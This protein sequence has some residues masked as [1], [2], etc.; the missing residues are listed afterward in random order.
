Y[1]LLSDDNFIEYSN[2]TSKGAKMPRGDKSAMMLFEVNLPNLDKQQEISAYLKSVDNKIQLNTQTNQTLEQIAQAIFKSWFVDFDP[3]KA[4]VD[5]LA[6]GGSQADAERTAMQ[7]IS[8]KTDAELTQM[9]Q[10]Q[11]DAYKTL[12]K[13][14]ALF[15]SE[16]VESE[17]GSVPKGWV[18]C[19]VGDVIE[20]VDYVANGSFASLKA[21]VTLLDEPNYAIYVRTTDFNAGFSKSLKYVDKKSYDFLKKSSLNGNEVII[22]NV[23]DVGTVFRPPKWLN[24][25]MTLGS[26][27]IALK[28]DAIS[29]YLYFYFNSNFGQWQINGITS[30]SAQMKFNKTG[31]R[32]LKFLVPDKDVLTIFESRLDAIY[33]KITENTKE[34]KLL[35]ENRDL[36]LPKLLSGE[37]EV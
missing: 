13:T 28:A 14:T 8:G 1:Y 10:T 19:K 6:N 7:V 17:L 11:P 9:Q 33:N 21:N 23:G 18:Y 35:S 29:H 2:L 16:M 22:S 5:A 30:G 27:A 12:E 4:K 15:P 31:F 26:N 20:V 34:N 32:N 37:L 3:V 24:M 36:L 25:P